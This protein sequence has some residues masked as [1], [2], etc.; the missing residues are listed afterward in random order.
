MNVRQWWHRAFLEKRP[1]LMLGLFRLAVA[2]TVGAHMI[3]SFFHMEDN[4]LSTAFKT[5]N[6][7]FF[8]LWI[9]RLVARSPEMSI[10]LGR[11]PRRWN[12]RAVP[13]RRPA[14]M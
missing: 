8:P 9:L 1:S 11:E 6:P 3:P 7:S 2:F 13:S 12:P 5:Q 14:R 4:F 10:S